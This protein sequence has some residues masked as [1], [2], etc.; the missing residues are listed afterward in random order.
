M[1]EARGELLPEPILV[2]VTQVAGASMLTGVLDAG[3]DGHSAVLALRSKRGRSTWLGGLP[4]LPWPRG[5]QG[6]Q[7]AL[8]GGWGDDNKQPLGKACCVTWSPPM[9]A[10]TPSHCTVRRGRVMRSPEFRLQPHYFADFAPFSIP[11]C[12]ARAQ[13]MDSGKAEF[14][15]SWFH[16]PA[17]SHLAW[18]I[19]TS[20]KPLDLSKS[21]SRGCYE[22]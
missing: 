20:Q 10:L 11:N 4:G 5:L 22:N 6:F 14:T 12:R 19:V 18:L 21:T 7:H 9:G 13:A 2:A 3:V 1:R 17:L 15:Y 8:G 16:I